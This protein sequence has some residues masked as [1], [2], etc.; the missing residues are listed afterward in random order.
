M[1]NPPYDPA[2]DD[3]MAAAYTI[4][5][6]CDSFES[7][8]KQGQSPEIESFLKE[9]SGK[10]QSIVFAELLRLDIHYRRMNGNLLSL[11]DY[12]SRFPQYSD[13][14]QDFSSQLTDSFRQVR[15]LGRYRLEKIVGRGAFGLV[16]KAWDEELQR[17]V[18]LKLPRKKSLSAVERKRF[19]RE[20][21]SAARL[22]HPGIV[23]IHDFE[24]IDGTLVLVTEFVEG[25]TLRE[26]TRH[27]E[28]DFSKAASICRD[29]AIA[30]HAAHQQSVIHRD[31][32]PNNV[33]VTDDDQLRITDFGL[34]KRSD[35]ESTIAV[36]GAIMGT[37]A[38]MSPEQADGKASTVDGRADIYSLGVILYELLTNRVPF[39]GNSCQEMI[40]QI[41]H[42]EPVPPH[43]WNASIP[44]DL[45]T[46]CLKSLSKLPGD[47]YDTA[48]ELAEDLQRFIEGKPITARR[49]S[50]HEK[51]W[52]WAKR[53]RLLSASL[54]TTCVL[55]LSS[56]TAMIVMHDDGK[57]QVNV[58]TE[59][60]GA[61][62]LVYPRDSISGEPNPSI[63]FEADGTTPTDL[64][65]APG[66]YYV[67]AMLEGTPRFQQVFRK[68][69]PRGAEIPIG[70]TKN[71][72]WNKTQA[73]TLEWPEIIIPTQSVLDEMVLIKGNQIDIPDL[74]VS[75]RCFTNHDY[76]TIRPDAS[77]ADPARHAPLDAPYYPEGQDFAIH[78]AEEAGGRLMTV[79]EFKHIVDSLP[80]Q[81]ALE[82]FLNTGK[83][84]TSSLATPQ[85]I[86][87]SKAA[88]DLNPE[89]RT[90][91]FIG[92]TIS[93]NQNHNQAEG[94][95]ELK[96]Q[97]SYSI[98]TAI[99]YLQPEKI[100]FRLVR[101]AS[102]QLKRE[103]PT[104]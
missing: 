19:S 17:T 31:L 2:D 37:F 65:L 71:R 55:L 100:G 61:R 13:I 50:L 42:T 5:R 1:N 103:Q 101:P 62:I 32:K 87:T 72:F 26:W 30:L 98:Q 33:L 102:Q 8:W 86:E 38:Y 35:V 44:R 43:K 96:N 51:L 28:V 46:I 73:N 53:N 85:Q 104:K 95:H 78:F 36:T 76:L 77:D 39:K 70:S 9:T 66:E 6:I 54:L 29:L 49:L 48:D 18:A 59:P 57:W 45:E 64:R 47:R 81:P 7:S 15:R 10:T 56:S 52:R 11:D 34:A 25:S 90:P 40:S 79:D 20:A 93:R 67:V 60:P 22:S 99:R 16:W 4:D 3:L 83:E 69:P 84:W 12:Q 80:L 92:L 27:H 91:D 75:T 41:L 82:N 94:N 97:K 74:Y 24:E 58:Q 63:E 23:S 21:R 89:F 68:V 14:L 88:L